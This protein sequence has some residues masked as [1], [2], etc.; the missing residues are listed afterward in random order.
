M[1]TAPAEPRWVPACR[2]ELVRIN[3]AYGIV[4]DVWLIHFDA[5]EYIPTHR[6]REKLLRFGYSWTPSERTLR[7]WLREMRR[8]V[9]SHKRL[10][11]RR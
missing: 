4:L 10:D 5:D 8:I 9:N 3:A 11:K 7:R 6:I 1:S 2:A